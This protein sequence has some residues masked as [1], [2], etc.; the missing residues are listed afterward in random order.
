MC[1]LDQM[2]LVWQKTKKKKKNQSETFWFHTF[3][4]VFWFVLSLVHYLF[5]ATYYAKSLARKLFGCRECPQ[6]LFLVWGWVR[7]Q[8]QT[9][10]FVVLVCATENVPGTSLGVRRWLEHC[11]PVCSVDFF[12]FQDFLFQLYSLC[13][14]SRVDSLLWQSNLFYST[15]LRTRTWTAGCKTP[16]GHTGLSSTPHQEPSGQ[17]QAWG[18][19]AKSQAA[20]ARRIQ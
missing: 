3:A 1:T 20:T 9:L 11:F 8:S 18:R 10:E 16:T 5:L 14:S 13:H 17:R 2:L 12:C 4:K 15:A 7:G 6:I 19:A